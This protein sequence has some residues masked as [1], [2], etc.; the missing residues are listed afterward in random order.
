VV[1]GY[2]MNDATLTGPWPDLEPGDE[3]AE[4][5]RVVLLPGAPFNAASW[6]L[7]RVFELERSRGTLALLAFSDPVRRTTLDGQVIL[8]GHV[9]ITY[10]ALCFTYAH[11]SRPRT[12]LLLPDGRAIVDRTLQ[13]IVAQERGWRGA[14]RRLV[15]AGLPAPTTAHHAAWARS[16]RSLLRPLKHRG[17][18]RYLLALD[19]IVGLPTRG[20]CP[21]SAPDPVQELLL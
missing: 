12:L 7:R 5:S 1:I 9:G 20:G 19:P 10:R 16:I 8:P 11:R 4:I 3:S 13:K 18:H 2:P 21:P 15:G 14:L 17:N 6:T